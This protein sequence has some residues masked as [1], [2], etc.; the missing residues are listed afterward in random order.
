M[1]NN[2][3]IAVGGGDTKKQKYSQYK[4]ICEIIKKFEIVRDMQ[5]MVKNVKDFVM[6]LNFKI[7]VECYIALVNNG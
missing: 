7:R 5:Y 2:E 4:K 3:K 1:R 6:H